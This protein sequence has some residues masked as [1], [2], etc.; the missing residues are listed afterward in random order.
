MANKKDK[1]IRVMF[2][3]KCQ[4]FNVKYVHGLGNIFGI[5]PRQQC[6]DCN[7][8]AMAFP[9]LEVTES[10]LKKKVKQMKAKNK[11]RKKK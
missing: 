3:P 2:C 5:I 7:L 9:I 4:S 1:K 8:V 10:E 11:A 6:L